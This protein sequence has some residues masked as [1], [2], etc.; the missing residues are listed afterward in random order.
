M[1]QAHM[2]WTEEE[3]AD[4]DEAVT[5]ADPSSRVQAGDVWQLGRNVLYCENSETRHFV[6]RMVSDHGYGQLVFTDPP[7][8]MDTLHGAKTSFVGLGGEARPMRPVHQKIS[9]MA[10]GKFDAKRFLALLP[11]Y[12]VLGKM[13]AFV[14]HAKDSTPDLYGWVADVRDGNVDREDMSLRSLRGLSCTPL[15]WYKGDEPGKANPFPIGKA[16]RPD[17]E[18]LMYLRHKGIWN[19]SDKA[20]GALRGR[21]LFH[22]REKGEHPTMKPVSLIQNQ[23]LLTTEPDGLVYDPY[24]GSGSTLIAAERCGRRCVMV[25]QLPQMCDLIL[26][27][28]EAETGREAVKV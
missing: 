26:S 6:D 10:M 24:G 12:F 18:Y 28:Y 17:V 1:S 23:L 13:A 21:V 22:K 19:N 16:H 20:P 8:Q 15:T 11:H 14:F 7:Y 2:D 9:A 5:L 4:Q 27:R 3:L 25:E